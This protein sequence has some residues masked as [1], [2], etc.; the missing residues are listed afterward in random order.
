V[1]V[2]DEPLNYNLVRGV[3]RFGIRRQA[4]V[5][6]FVLVAIVLIATG[7]GF[8]PLSTLVPTMAVGVATPPEE[9]GAVEVSMLFASGPPSGRPAI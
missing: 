5:K 8:E 9:A 3:L 7:C 1:V 6:R 2:L 4:G